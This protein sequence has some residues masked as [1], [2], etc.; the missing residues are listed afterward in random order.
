MQHA[1]LSQNRS[2]VV[3]ALSH[4]PDHFSDGAQQ[5]EPTR[6]V[7]WIFFFLWRTEVPRSGDPAGPT[8]ALF[9]SPKRRVREAFHAR[10]Y[11]V[12]YIPCHLEDSG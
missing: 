4:F 1:S 9:P 12:A 6:D 3:M 7:L 2:P 8:S 10:A 5:T 11:L